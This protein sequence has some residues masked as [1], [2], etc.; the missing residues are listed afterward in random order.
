MCSCSVGFKLLKDS[1]TCQGIY[2][3]ISDPPENC[4]LNVKKLPKAIFFQKIAIFFSKY[5]Q[6]TIFGN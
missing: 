6:M 1:R 2:E 5:C 3:Y 4:H